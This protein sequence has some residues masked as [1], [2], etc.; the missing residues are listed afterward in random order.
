MIFNAITSS[1]FIVF[2]WIS[3]TLNTHWYTI[4]TYKKRE[5]LNKQDGLTIFKATTQKFPKWN[6][7]KIQVVEESKMYWLIKYWSSLLIVF[8]LQG[9]C[10]FFVF[11]NSIFYFCNLVCL[12]FL[13]SFELI[14]FSF[15]LPTHNKYTCFLIITYSNEINKIKLLIFSLQNQTQDIHIKPNKSDKST[16]FDRI[17]YLVT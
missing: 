3:I 2:N 11:C 4:K 12:F 9:W 7:V 8:S 1:T 6:I 16:F 13:H 15:L 10:L 5:K 17:I 14:L